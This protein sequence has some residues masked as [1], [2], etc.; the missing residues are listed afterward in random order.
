MSVESGVK[1]ATHIFSMYYS[2]E[3]LLCITLGHK[4]KVRNMEEAKR[5]TCFSVITLQIGLIIVS[6][7]PLLTRR[8]VRNVAFISFYHS[9]YF[10]I[11][12]LKGRGSLVFTWLYI[13]HINCLL[14][15]IAGGWILSSP[16]ESSRESLKW[17]E[18][19]DRTQVSV[20][21]VFMV[22]EHPNETSD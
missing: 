10:F 12:A 14:S 6:L 3:S 13:D 17:S 15:H 1:R 8:L 2:L 21:S 18:S 20:N 11:Q 22:C 16:E 5:T 9:R 7:S 19:T 4:S